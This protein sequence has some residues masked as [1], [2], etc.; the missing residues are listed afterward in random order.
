MDPVRHV[1]DDERRAR[2][3]LRLGL[4][5]AVSTVE[6]AARSVVALHATE[7]ASVALSAL[8]RSPLLTRSDVDEA[9]AGRRLV[10]QLSMRRTLFAMPVDLLPAVRAR[11]CTRIAPRVRAELRKGVALAGIAT[12]PEAWIGR[13]VAQI[14]RVLNEGEPLSV[15]ELRQRAPE[16]VGSY[17]QGE[18]TKW[19]PP[20][21][22]PPR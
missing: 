6:D 5:E 16:A 20:T 1:S 7:P 21:N 2:L 22:S 4:A 19:P 10:K 12:D 17:R 3:G 11:I 9:F 13:A 18:D 14:V 8:A 15:Q